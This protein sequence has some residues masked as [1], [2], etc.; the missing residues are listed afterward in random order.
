MSVE[1]IETYIK[2]KDASFSNGHLKLRVEW[3]IGPYSDHYSVDEKLKMNRWI[4]VH[5]SEPVSVFVRIKSNNEVCGKVKAKVD[6]PWPIDDI[7]TQVS[8]CIKL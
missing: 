5:K 3:K 4:K 7:E 8:K 1:A 2:L 6:M